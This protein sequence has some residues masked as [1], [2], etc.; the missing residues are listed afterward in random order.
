[1]KL[2][3]MFNGLADDFPREAMAGTGAPLDPND[4]V[5]IPTMTYLIDHPEGKIL[6]DTGWTSR[7]KLTFPISEKE[8]VVNT[9]ARI[10]VRPEEIK[11]LILSHLHLDHAGNLEPFEDAEILVSETEFSEVA[12]LLLS[13]KLGPPFVRA[14]VEAWSNRDFRWRLIGGQYE[15]VDFVPGVKFVTLGPGHSFGILALLVELPRSG[16]VLI[17]S[18]AIYGSVNVGPPVRPPGVIMDEAGYRKSLDFLL[19]TAKAYNAELWYGHDLEQF[20][21]LTKADAGYYE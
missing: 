9:L 19:A 10:G 1:M 18:D 21:T 17:A 15:V 6:Y 14:D 11:Y 5:S 16:N 3:V 4:V 2:Y 20:E 7:Q 12:K 8:Y 13:N